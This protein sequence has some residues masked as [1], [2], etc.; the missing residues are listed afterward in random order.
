MSNC[1]MRWKAIINNRKLAGEILDI[2]GDFIDLLQFYDHSFLL[3]YLNQL[4]ENCGL[5]P[6]IGDVHPVS[7]NNNGE[8]YQ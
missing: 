8:V 2:P 4:A 1:K 5:L 3:G 6:I 7:E